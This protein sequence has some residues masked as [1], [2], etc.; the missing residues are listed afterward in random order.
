MGH[1]WTIAATSMA[2]I[3][4]VAVELESALARESRALLDD[5]LTQSVLVDSQGLDVT[6]L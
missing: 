1:V 4:D 6:F 3:R 5:H 2:R